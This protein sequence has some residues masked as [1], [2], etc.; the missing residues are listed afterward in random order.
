MPPRATELIN[1]LKLQPHPEGG[2]FREVYRSPLPVLLADG[3]GERSALTTIYFL[4]T[5]GEHS[6]VHR[7]ISDEIWHYY[8]G[9]PLHLLWWTMDYQLAG[10]TILGAPRGAVNPIAIVPAGYWQAA[11]STGEYSLVNCSVTPGF[12]FTDFQLL[13][14]DASGVAAFRKVQS[15]WAHLI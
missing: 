12:D 3:R 7:V 2:H 9:D 4:L 1:S 8:E 5:S 14:D 10:Q 11:F 13:H 15:Q 6:R